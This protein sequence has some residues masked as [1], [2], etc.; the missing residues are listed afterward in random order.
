[1]KTI[2]LE[3]WLATRSQDAR[4]A[5]T[6]TEDDNTFL[7]ALHDEATGETFVVTIGKYISNPGHAPE[8]EG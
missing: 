7:T 4:L 2:K 1:M 8:G 6:H 3:N 5:V